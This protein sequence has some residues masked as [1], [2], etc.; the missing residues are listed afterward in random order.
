MFFK[1]LGRYQKR[2]KVG[3]PLLSVEASGTV[4][5]TLT[6]LRS[7]GNNVVRARVIPTNPQTMAQSQARIV[8]SFNG[9]ASKRINLNQVGKADSATMTPKE[10]LISIQTT[11][12]TWVSAFVQRGFPDGRVTFEADIAAYA[13]LTEQ[14]KTAWT[15]WNTALP[16]SFGV[17]VAP[18]G[19]APNVEAP[20]AAFLFARGMA[21]A[22]Y[23]TPVPA[24]TPP[25]WDNTLRA[26]SREELAEQKKNPDGVSMADKI[27]QATKEAIAG[28]KAKAPKPA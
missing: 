4:A 9:E 5:Q 15:T 3:G 17:I 12:G 20:A 8:L 10:Y 26:L 16:N 11:T 1:N 2:A 7:R 23:I 18:A 21:R 6:F 13:A 27:A 14:E 28:V 19:G 25:T 22:G 24:G